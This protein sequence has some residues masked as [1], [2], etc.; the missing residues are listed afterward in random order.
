MPEYLRALIVILTLAFC[1]C[2]FFKPA[3][4]SAVPIDDFN[5]RRKL[6]F[7]LT[8][9]VFLSHSFW[10]CIV[11][12]GIALHVF[13]KNDRN[14][15]AAYFFLLFAI[16]PI[17]ALIPGFGIVN[18]LFSI[19]YLRLL[20]LVL[21]LPVLLH[22]SRIPDNLPLPSSAADLCVLG[23]IG[24]YTVLI[25]LG[26][27]IS[28]LARNVFNM[29]VDIFL[30]YYAASRVLSTPERFRDAIGSFVIAAALMAPVALFEM[31][32][33]WMLYAPLGSVLGVPWAFFSYM[34][35]AG[36]L[37]AAS[38]AGHPLVLAYAMVVALG[39][40]FYIQHFIEKKLLRNLLWVLLLFGLIA[41]ISRG[42][43]MGGVVVLLLFLVTGQYSSKQVIG[44]LVALVGVTVSIGMSP[45]GDKVTALL[46][47]V[48]H[49][50]EFNVSYRQQLI[51]NSITLLKSSPL[52]GVPNAMATSEM[53]SMRQGE[54]IIDIVNTYVAIG[55]GSGVTGLSLFLGV[56]LS[57]GVG[58]FKAIRQTRRAHP[59]LHLLGRVLFAILCSVLFMIATL[60]SIMTVPII[61]W[62]LAGMGV[63]YLALVRRTLADPAS[64][65]IA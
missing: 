9:L 31:T 21:L 33:A 40:L 18:V 50:D 7:F 23:Y 6:W 65:K 20:T 15:V 63:A 54:G 48:G 25:G 53:Q 39:F 47:F 57:V 56:F 61:Y 24:L 8:T 43:W 49:V 27:S 11:A 52:F 28:D 10:L 34:V 46:P 29:F 30:P 17:G 62:M 14:K 4:I 64:S 58:I 60:S 42:P 5:R 13:T 19:D 41:P 16:P 35:R 55:L 22:R 32:R 59:E 44:W 38:S 37:R 45:Y 2:L 26:T 1:T 36:G 12:S 3:F 51:E